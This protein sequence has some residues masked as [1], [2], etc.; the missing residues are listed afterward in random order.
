MSN[1]LNRVGLLLSDR[2]LS[3]IKG[4]TPRGCTNRPTHEA[5]TLVKDIV[6]DISDAEMLNRPSNLCFVRF[7]GCGGLVLWFNDKHAGL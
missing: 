2:A 5:M 6:Y 3:K 7:R 4:I 1:R